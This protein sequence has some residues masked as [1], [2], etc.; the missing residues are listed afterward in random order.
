MLLL[1]LILRVFLLNT[2]IAFFLLK[3]VFDVAIYL[4]QIPWHVQ[5]I[6]RLLYFSNCSLFI[7]PFLNVADK[8]EISQRKCEMAHC[9]LE[10]R[11]FPTSQVDFWQPAF[12]LWCPS[13]HQRDKIE[14]KW[15]SPGLESLCETDS[16]CLSCLCSQPNR[17]NPL[18]PHL[19]KQ[20]WLVSVL[21]LLFLSLS[22]QNLMRKSFTQTASLNYLDVVLGSLKSDFLSTCLMYSDISKN[23]G[24]QGARLSNI[25]RCSTRF[26]GT[27]GDETGACLLVLVAI[28][29]RAE[30]NRS[31]VFYSTERVDVN[32]G[33]PK[34]LNV[35]L[36][37]WWLLCCASLLWLS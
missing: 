32:R 25:S 37:E 23:V 33:I 31:T 21:S 15:L 7:N 28:T 11:I 34:P 35:C 10:E 29:K 2:T 16:F 3:C 17:W 27:S 30:L 22:V 1:V 4:C 9:W 13:L 18:P 36:K 24:G 6:V 12:Y 19:R 14:P 26:H 20:S 8:L 5:V